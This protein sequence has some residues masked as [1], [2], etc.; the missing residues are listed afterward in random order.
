MKNEILDGMARAF[1]AC[2]WAEQCEEAEQESMLSGREI[3]EI[4]PDKIDP[5]AI[6]AAKTLA[7]DFIRAQPYLMKWG[8]DL[9]LL[10]RTFISAKLLDRAGAD[11]ELTPELFGHYLAMQSMGTGVGLESFGYAVR[12]FF[13]VPHVE[14]GGYSLEKDYF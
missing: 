10:N 1:F 9:D 2:A 14:F 6:H 11:R 4:M 13:T 7:M 3:M 5:A 8:A 12:D